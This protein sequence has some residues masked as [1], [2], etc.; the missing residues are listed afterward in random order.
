MGGQGCPVFLKVPIDL[1]ESER[2]ILVSTSLEIAAKNLLFKGFI[3]GEGGVESS[4]GQ[5]LAGPEI[6]Q[7]SLVFLADMYRRTGKKLTL[8]ASGGVSSGA[9]VLDRLEAGA[10]FVQL[11]SGLLYEGPPIARRIK[12]ELS[13]LMYKEG[14][15]CIDEAVGA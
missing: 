11:Y 8:I 1:T 7:A 14:Y 9:D 13:Q 10:S 5:A 6:S 4:S 12:T 2:E 3:V 15:T